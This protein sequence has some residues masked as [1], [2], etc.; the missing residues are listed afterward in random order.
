M[1]TYPK[2][3]FPMQFKHQNR[4]VILR[5]LQA[6][7]RQ[8]LIGF[9]Q[10]LPPDDLLFLQRDITQEDEVD[11]W[12]QQA[13]A[14]NLSTIVATHEDAILGY[15]TSDRGCVRWTRHV[16]EL[17]VVVAAGSRGTGI[18]RL[19]LELVFEIAL[20]EGVTKLIARMTPSQ[21]GAAS[22]FERLGFRQEAV[23][24]DHALSADGVTHDLLVLSF[25]TRLHPEQRCGLCGAPVLSALALDGAGLCSTCYETRYLELGGGA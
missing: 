10:N 7:D 4:T 17:R 19:L 25:Q 24:R 14:G 9:A 16:A 11:W 2:H 13:A 5:P 20:G 12:I 15:A 21:T 6:S 3:H 22:L 8:A 23:L 1:K 18:G